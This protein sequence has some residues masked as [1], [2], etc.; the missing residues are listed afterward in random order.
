MSFRVARLG[1]PLERHQGV[2]PKPIEIGA[3]RV[4]ASRIQLVQPAVAD[5]PPD[6]EV[7]VLQDAQMLLSRGTGM[8]RPRRRTVQPP[9]APPAAPEPAA[10]AAGKIDVEGLNF[11]YGPRRVLEQ[12][13]VRIRPNQV[14]ALIGP[15]GCG[16]ST[17]LRTSTG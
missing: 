16:K 14:T 11:F 10:E 13:S 5:G 6:D 17:F 15:S 8:R 1:G 12:I 9:Q 4:D 7:R 3:Q 2:V